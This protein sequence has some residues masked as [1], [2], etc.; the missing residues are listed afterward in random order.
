M[1]IIQNLFK[2]AFFRIKSIA[3]KVYKGCAVFASGFTVFILV[4][5]NDQISGSRGG[6]VT[7]AEPIV[8]VDMG[9]KLKKEDAEAAPAL[10]GN[11]GTAYREFLETSPTRVKEEVEVEISKREVEA[12]C[13]QAAP[14]AHTELQQEPINPYG[15]IV[16]AEEDYDALCRIVQAEAGGEDLQGRTLVAEVV[17]NRVLS[18][19]YASTVYDV[20]FEKSGGKPQFSPTVDGRFFSVTV[21][22]DTINAVEQALHGEDI[23]QGA[24]FFSARSKANPNDMAWFDNHLKW[25]FQHGG[26]EFYTLP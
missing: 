3:K 12:V 8:L 18:E 26:H 7:A 15:D 6:R 10:E 24:L 23:S 25:L 2:N 20:V 21:T 11:L 13:A 19:N 4:F 14:E 9:E 16:I 17:L 22:T 5:F 1:L